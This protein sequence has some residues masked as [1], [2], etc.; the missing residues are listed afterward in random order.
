MEPFVFALLMAWALV[1]YGVTDLVATVN[2]T[3]SP[4]YRERQQR[5]TQQHE[6]TIARLQT[7]PTVGQAVA[8]RLAQRIAHPKPPTD[9]SEHHPLRRFLSQWWEDSW[10]HATE[11][12]HRHHE[13]K[14]HGKLPRQRAAH[15]VKESCRH[16]YQRWRARPRTTEPD[17]DGATGTSSS[18]TGDADEHMTPPKSTE[19]RTGPIRVASARLIPAENETR[20]GPAP[21]QSRNAEPD[22]ATPAADRPGE[23]D[24]PCSSRDVLTPEAPT[25][26]Q[27]GS[28]DTMTAEPSDPTPATHNGEVT[29]LAT[30]LEYTR[31]MGEQFRSATAHVETLT[32]QAQQVADW[33][34]Q[35]AAS[36]ET[37]LAGI[38][39]G[40]VTGEA[41]R[42]LHVA[43]DQI[44]AAATQVVA[45]QR[46]LAAAQEQFGTTAESFDTA[47]TAFARQQTVAEAYAANPDAGS[48]QFNTLS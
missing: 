13:R 8:G 24:T 37:S 34:E 5:L 29:N 32:A 14:H 43:R 21:Q 42:S 39:E 19:Q 17:P 33:A 26:R 44:T 38:T 28:T 11:R 41:V 31:G 9:R 23:T 6:R 27:E 12:R 16:W 10:N 40:E 15:K 36:A 48:K 25:P 20:P 4:R 46:E 30:A 35:T 1:R 2:G 45:A 47:Y 7:G 22:G 18:T 3:E